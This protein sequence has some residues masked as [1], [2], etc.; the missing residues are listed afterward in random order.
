MNLEKIKQKLIPII[1]K[2]HL[3]VYS[4]RT[5]KEYGEKIVEILLDTDT[6]DIDIL[7]K[8]H[9]EFVETLTDDDL[10]PDYFLELSSLGAERPLNTKEQM[11]QAVSKYVY[12]ESPKYKGNGTLLSFENDII[13]LEINDKGRIKKIEIK[14]NDAKNM[15]TAIKF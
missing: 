14:F 1:S 13:L 15:R 10:D 9:L 3:C 5:K 11:I 8:I 2:S 12:L 7:E 6:I 4:I